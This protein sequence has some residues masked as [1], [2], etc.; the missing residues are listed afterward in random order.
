MYLDS[1]RRGTA[2]RTGALARLTGPGGSKRAVAGFFPL[3]CVG[4]GRERWDCGAGGDQGGAEGAGR[5]R[6]AGA[7]A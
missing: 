6:R 4:V 5:V 2:S 7:D 1:D 3:H